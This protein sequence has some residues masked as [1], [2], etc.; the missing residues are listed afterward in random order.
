[1]IEEPRDEGFMRDN[2]RGGRGSRRPD[3]T[4]RPKKHRRRGSARIVQA[5]H[6]QPGMAIPGQG[7]ILDVRRPEAHTVEAHLSYAPGEDGKWHWPILW[8][9]LDEE[10]KVTM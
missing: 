5:R 2:A 10:V 3:R 4:F 9:G 7:H 1:M 6:L 8:F